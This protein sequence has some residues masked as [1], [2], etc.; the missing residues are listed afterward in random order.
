[1]STDLSSAAP[2]TVR[3][4]LIEKHADWTFERFSDHWRAWHGPLAAQVPGLRGYWQ[5]VVTDREQRG[6]AFA[7]GPWN[8]DGFSQLWFDDKARADA[9]FTQGELAQRLI[10]DENHFIGKLH[11]I[12][13]AQHTVIAVP[14]LARRARL[15]KRIS[16]LKR[17]PGLSE[18]DFRRE[19]VVHGDRKSVV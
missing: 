4:G 9:G 3:M 10:A 16:I 1:M 15:L 2:L 11:I 13:T 14:P 18:A 6:I 12:T 17:Q 8:F 19:W 5:N 7:R